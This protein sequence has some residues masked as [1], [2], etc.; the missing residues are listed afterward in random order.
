[1][2]MELVDLHAHTT[3]SDGHD[4]PSA[5]VKMAAENNLAVLGIA[6]HD[7]LGGLPEA[8]AA[9][10][11]HGVKIVCGVEITTGFHGSRLHILGLGIDPED[12]GFRIF[13]KTIYDH[14]KD[15]MIAKIKVFAEHSQSVGGAEIEI[16]DFI[17]TQGE[18]FN[19]EGAAKYLVLKGFGT[20]PNE[21]IKKLFDIRVG[22]E[23]PI[24]PMG[25]VEAVHKAKGLVVLAHPFARGAS[26][27]KLD[28]TISGQETLLKELIDIGIDGFE[29]YQSEHDPEAVLLG[30][31]LAKKYGLLVSGGSDWH[32]VIELDPDIKNRKSAYPDHLGGL[33]ITTD[34]VAPLLERLGL[35]GRPRTEL[36]SGAGVGK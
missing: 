35:G 14:R 5:L 24:D 34:M 10:K 33:G 30:L 28:P 17:K 18:Y 12:I 22:N 23:F 32:G 6:D 11:K 1:M 2:F 16:E 9:G 36:G 7:N 21:V 26:L 25:V 8:L 4:T 29:C 20:D 13:L 3:F 31:E 19:H 27:R 15:A